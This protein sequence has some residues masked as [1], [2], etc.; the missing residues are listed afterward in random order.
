MVISHDDTNDILQNTFMKA[1]SNIDSFRGDSKLLTWLYRIATNET[2][3]FLNSKRLKYTASIDEVD[4]Y[5]MNSLHADASF[6]GNEAE[7][8]LQMAILT[9]P[10]KQR[11]VFNMK[12]FDE[13]TYEQM[14]EVLDTS[15]GGLKASYHHAVKKVHKYLEENEF[16]V[17]SPVVGELDSIP[18]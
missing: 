12:Y 6:D 8:K 18:D 13:M 16:S 11:L 15:V 9:L 14:Q 5:L 7:I 17:S 1:W 10:E 2:I 3:T 4:S